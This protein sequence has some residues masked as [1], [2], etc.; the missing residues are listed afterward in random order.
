LIIAGLQDYI[1][2]VTSVAA[3]RTALGYKFF[4]A[5]THG[6]IAAITSLNF[7]LY[8]IHEHIQS[9]ASHQPVCKPSLQTTG[10]LGTLLRQSL[11]YSFTVFLYT[12]QSVPRLF[13]VLRSSAKTLCDG[14]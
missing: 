7:Y 10:V 3:I 13:L 2:A 12:A 11:R 1:P 5:K 4:M 9:F 6:A 14:F 8:S